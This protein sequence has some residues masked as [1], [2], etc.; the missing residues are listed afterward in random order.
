MKIKQ[1]LTGCFILLTVSVFAQTYE[2][3]NFDLPARKTTETLSESEKKES[4]VLLDDHRTYEYATNPKDQIEIFYTRHMRVHINEQSMV[5]AYNKIYI[6]VGS[7]DDLVT[8]HSRTLRKDGTTLDLYKGDMKMVS[9]EGR[10]YMILAIE[11]LEKDAELEYYYTTREDIRV[12]LSE[13]L[14]SHAYSRKVRMD[15]IAP[16]HLIFEAKVYN[17][18]AMISDTVA[19][20]KR[21]V[22]I[23][24]GPISPLDDEEKYIF[25]GANVMRVEFKLV[26]NKIS[27]SNR[28]YTWDDA[29]GRF[30]EIFHEFDKSDPK[31][32]DKLIS[33]AGLKTGTEE[34]KVKKIERFMKTNV[35]VNENNEEE[36]IKLML[37]RKYGSTTQVVKTY[38]ALFEKLNIPYEMV[39]TCDRSKGKF[40][41]DFDTWN[42][43]DEYIFYFP[44]S[45]KYMDP[46]NIIYRYGFIPPLF[47]ENY[48]LFIRNVTLG[49]VVSGVSTVKKIEP[50]KPELHFDN[51]TADITLSADGEKATIKIDREMAGYADNNLKAVYFYTGE[52]DRKKI[53]EDYM[54]SCGGEG[55]EFKS[56]SAFNFDMNSEEYYKPFVLNATIESA[57]IIEKAG[58][59]ILVSIGLVI[60][61]QMELYQDHARQNPID[62]DFPHSYKRVLKFHVPDGYTPK[63]L[64]KLKMNII[65]EDKA[66]MGFTS[67][68]TLEG[69]VLTVTVNEYYTQT[70]LP[71]TSY[72]PF[73]RVINAAADFNKLKVILEKN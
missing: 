16:E 15:I 46:T 22:T 29:G 47:T 30:Y 32:I 45:G 10:N 56:S 39:V 35:G 31:E 59:T 42:F 13:R 61:Q 34:E 4:A 3:R 27:N 20:D 52:D 18:K 7:P 66:Q 11:G 26:Q 12:F 60:G 40:D 63:G 24:A 68:Y 44:F 6:P 65:G 17:G 37:S 1:L 70:H 36:N 73:R 2:T 38:V 8:M 58:N 5:E 71:A 49:D 62:Q 28:L 72:E 57:G 41:P 19:N 23:T 33:K 51:M 25:Y 43:L 55:A 9:E 67:D 69:N 14:Q 54:K 21:W 50:L 64:E 48:G 53:F